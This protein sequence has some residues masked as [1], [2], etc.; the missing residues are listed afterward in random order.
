MIL[1]S[2]SYVPVLRWR[3][4]E[5]QALH[6]LAPAVRARVV[7]LITI[8]QI[9]YDF[10]HQRLKKTVQEFVEPFVGRY[11][12]KWGFRP[13]WIALDETIAIGRM[14]GGAHVFDH[15]F[16]GLRRNRTRALPA[17]GLRDDLDT[18]AAA[19]RAVS[20]GA[21]GVG[22]IVGLEDLAS[23]S[24]RD[25]VEALGVALGVGLDRL[26][27]VMDLGAPTTYE[28]YGEF[29]TALLYWMEGLG[30]L[31]SFRNLVVTGTAIPRS[32]R[33][34]GRG[35][36]EIA[37]HDWMFYKT[38]VQ[39]L[40]EGMR[41][42]AYGDYTIVHPDFEAR[43]PRRMKPAAKL[44]YT[45]P[46]SWATRKGGS[47]RDDRGQMRGHCK[48]VMRDSHFGYRGSGYSEGDH[49][50]MTCATGMEG[51]GSLGRWKDAGMTHHITMVVEDLAKLAAGPSNA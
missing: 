19:A 47:F 35:N 11:V 17:V 6:R 16:D 10:E 37:R 44:I 27:L 25:E 28:P 2:E 49:R 34:I 50:I 46:A 38:L 41:R 23:P 36:D 20:G 42:P 3:Q 21:D 24:V 18:V 51:T 48:C 30:S 15:I 14:D 45:K 7:P 33:G 26:D 31:G 32:F 12:Q 39:N 1:G 29:A 22:V 4:A 43:D 8:P 13:G 40:P 9:E 5:Y